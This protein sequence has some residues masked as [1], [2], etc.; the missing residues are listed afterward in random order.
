[1]DGDAK[2]EQLLETVYLVDP[3]IQPASLESIAEV[4]NQ[5]G[6]PFPPG[7][8]AF[9]TRLG[10]GV[11]CDMVRVYEPSRILKETP[12]FQESMD[13]YYHWSGLSQTEATTS[14]IIGDSVDGDR[15]VFCP[16]RPE[17]LF[18]LPRHDLRAM[19]LPWDLLTAMEALM[20]PQSMLPF[21]YFQPMIRQEVQNFERSTDL[22][23]LALV[24]DRLLKLGTHQGLVDFTGEDE[25]EIQLF[26]KDIYGSLICA[27]D[28]DS[29]EVVLSYAPEKAENIQPIMTCLQELGFLDPELEPD[30]E[31]RKE[32]DRLIYLSLN[33]RHLV[34]DWGPAT[35]SRTKATPSQK[36]MAHHI[37]A[38][39]KDQILFNHC[40][41]CGKLARTPRARQCFHCGHA[42]RG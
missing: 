21:P 31:E 36:K 29:V 38:H 15:L 7:Y 40:G 6:V 13:R 4:S 1:M 11:F 27:E 37:L 16:S 22:V 34:P 25:E 41:K 18:V 30:E 10:R 8:E 3:R 26:Y 28:M 5:S 24:K 20:S 12:D 32:M 14:I 17:N 39:F 19:A 9:I 35:F 2:M 42:W 33:Y 23:S